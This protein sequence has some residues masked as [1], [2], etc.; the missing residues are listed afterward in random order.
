[1]NDLHT[2]LPEDPFQI[3]IL[4]VQ[5]LSHFTRTV[6]LYPWA[7]QSETTIGNIELMA[8]S[9]GITL[10]HFRPFIFHISRPEIRFDESGDGTILHKGGEHFHRK[11]KIRRDA[12]HVRLGAGRLH[13]KHIGALYRLC[14]YRRNA[15]PHTGG[16]YQRIFILF[17]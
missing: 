10:R 12:C 3:E 11:S 4:Y 2:L 13:T 1:M 9:P 15:Y 17:S 6:V 16:N 7:T 5:R 8:I 14:I